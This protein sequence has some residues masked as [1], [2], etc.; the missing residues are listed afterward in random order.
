VK[1]LPGAVFPAAR[2]HEESAINKTRKNV[3][4]FFAR[5]LNAFIFSSALSVNVVIVQY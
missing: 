1:T 5:P 4:F 2:A 3:D